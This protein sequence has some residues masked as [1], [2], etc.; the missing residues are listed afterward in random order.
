[1]AG[2]S[3]KIPLHP[4][5]NVKRLSWLV[6][7]NLLNSQDKKINGRNYF[8]LVK[9]RK[10]KSEKRMTHGSVIGR[11]GLN[12]TW[13]CN[14]ST[15]LEG[16]KKKWN[17]L[18]SFYFNQPHVFY[19]TNMPVFY[20]NKYACILCSNKYACILCSTNMHVFMYAFFL[21]FFIQTWKKSLCISFWCMHWSTF[22]F[23]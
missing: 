10:V 2:S 11:S 7:K 20:F 12:F 6:C 13:R 5:Q 16:V 3:K 17:Q 21:S 15:T 22:Q 1:M 8:I 4:K 14:A 9:K 23:S 18:R 19:F